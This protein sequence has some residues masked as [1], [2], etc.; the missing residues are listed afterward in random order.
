MAKRMLIDRFL[1]NV[2]T[3][4]HDMQDIS[5]IL[6]AGCGE[7]IVMRKLLDL[8]P[9]L[10]IEGLD[11]S[12]DSLQVAKQAL[13]QNK[14]YQGS[15]M[16]MPISD[17]QYDLVMSLEVLE[18]VDDPEAALREIQKRAAKYCLISVPLEPYFSMGNLITG[19]NIKRWGKDP[20]HINFWSRKDIVNLIAKYFDIQDSKVSFPW[21]IVVGRSK[22]KNS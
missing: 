22:L 21:T 20:E 7:A 10:N 5:T 4:I 6:D 18:H 11:I 9:D 8:R 14:F 1:D 3:T 19:S 12:A 16:N 13:P 17:K 2:K 15:I